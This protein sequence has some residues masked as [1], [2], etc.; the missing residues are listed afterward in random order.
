MTTTLNNQN[1]EITYPCEWAIKV[2]GSD[3]KAMCA[4]ADSIIKG[5]A[6]TV[7]PSNTSRTGKYVSIKIKLTLFSSEEKNDIYEKFSKHKEIKFV[8]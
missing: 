5:A 4:I 7:S 2:I 1:L 6:Y 8:L 3:E